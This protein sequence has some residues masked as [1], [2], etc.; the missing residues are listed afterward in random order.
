MATQ[1]FAVEHSGN[2][3]IRVIHGRDDNGGIGL[4]VI[5]NGVVW[6]RAYN[7]AEVT[8]WFKKSSKANVAAWQDAFHKCGLTAADFQRP[9]TSGAVD[10]KIKYLSQRDNEFHPLGTCNVTC[11]A[12]A[13]GYLGVKRQKLAYRQFED[14]LFKYMENHGLDR[15]VHDDLA[16]T[17]R[18]YGVDA[19]FSTRRTLAEID[20]EIRAGN[21][22]IVSTTL[23]KSGHIIL[24]RGITEKGDYIVNDPY[25]NAISGYKDRNG[26]GVIYERA[27]MDV[28][29]RGG[30]GAPKWAHFLR[31]K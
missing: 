25:G 5:V 8:A 19:T 18:A 13:L 22:V 12:M 11:Y 20:A 21:P 16:A 2:S 6:L 29:I 31:K 1:I 28:K 3:A 15:H 4:D 27:F 24:L 17:G 30:K 14:E 9:A 26:E 10:N 23:T 7:P